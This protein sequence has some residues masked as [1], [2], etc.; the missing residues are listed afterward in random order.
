M[1]PFGKEPPG[2][3]CAWCERPGASIRILMS[4]EH[5]VCD[6]CYAVWYETDPKDGAELRERSLGAD[7]RAAEEM[8]SRGLS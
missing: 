1:S 6:I 7:G 3:S 4:R 5:P 8:L 2:P